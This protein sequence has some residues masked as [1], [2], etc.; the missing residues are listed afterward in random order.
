MAYK[1]CW[2]N[3]RKCKKIVAALVLMNRHINQSKCKRCIM[4]LEFYV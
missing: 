2:V 4:S 1:T 3:V